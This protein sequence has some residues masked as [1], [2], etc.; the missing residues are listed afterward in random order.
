MSILEKG[1]NIFLKLSLAMPDLD[2]QSSRI[3]IHRLIKVT[4]LVKQGR[5]DKNIKIQNR[6]YLGII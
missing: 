4:L 6:W 3:S 2:A 1:L 5:K